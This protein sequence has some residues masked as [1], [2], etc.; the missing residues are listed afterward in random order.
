MNQPKG[1]LTIVVAPTFTILKD[2][3][4]RMFEE[5]YGDSG[6]I[7]SHNKTDMETRIKGD[8]TI[9]WRSADKPDRL[10][11]TNAGAAY[12]DEASYADEEVYRVLLG[13]LRKE[14]GRFWMTFT[15]R[16]KNHWTYRMISSGV[17]EM[18]HAP[19][20]SNSFNPD[21]FVNS[22]KQSYDGSFYSQE[23]EGLFVDTDGALMK[24]SWIK[25]WEGDMPERLI[26]CRAWDCAATLGKRSDFTVGTLMGLIPGTETVIILD[27]VRKQYAAENVDPLIVKQSDTDGM[28]T[29][30][31]IEV[32]PGS[33][34]KRLLSHQLNVLQGRKVAWANVGGSKLTR[35]V[36]FSRAASAGK[37]F[38]C[39]GA[40]T[41]PCFAEIDAFTG[42][43]ADE[44]DDCVDSISLGF[45]HLCGSMRK[46]IAV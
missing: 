10:R 3:T 29:T 35:A 45:S 7:V 40:W 9:L 31:V 30:I 32:E 39:P 23:V 37:V 34:G 19:T 24:S 11:G 41:G 43:A 22:L 5:L 12:M 4:F 46:V 14:P 13:R 15:P 21:F 1:C 6:L 8:R 38:Y 25:P 18:I 44:H 33:A 17:V 42:T 2:S 16:G 27:Q 36:P 20:Y 28:M 26:L